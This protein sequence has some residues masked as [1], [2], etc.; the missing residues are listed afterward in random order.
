MF[1]TMFESNRDFLGLLLK[2]M[3]FAADSNLGFAPSERVVEFDDGL[4]D[5]EDKE[6]EL[7]DLPRFL[8][9]E[10]RPRSRSRESERERERERE[11]LRERRELE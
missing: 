10:C 8:P 6:A 1:E 3:L 7:G 4:A 11:R 9:L 2:A 5:E